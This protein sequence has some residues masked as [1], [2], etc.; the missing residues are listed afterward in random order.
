M[1]AAAG[2]EVGVD[3]AVEEVTVDAVVEVGVHVVVGPAGAVGEMEGVVAA[4][5][6]AEVGARGHVFLNG[7][8]GRRVFEGRMKPARWS[9]RRAY[10]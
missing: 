4:A 10:I 3:D 9:Q 6:G 1:E 8:L 7:A 5:A 2:D